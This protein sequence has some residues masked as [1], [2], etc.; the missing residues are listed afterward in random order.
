MSSAEVN[1]LE[2]YAKRA[3]KLFFGVFGFL[4][5]MSFGLGFIYNNLILAMTLGVLSAV[6]PM[7]LIKFRPGS[8]LTK[9]VV[10]LGFMMF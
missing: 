5:A 7:A 10:A 8:V 9:N 1:I 6:M 3:D 4:L 2:V